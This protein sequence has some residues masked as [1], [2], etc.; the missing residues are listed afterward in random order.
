MIEI[1]LKQI[2]STAANNVI[3]D[4]IEIPDKE[5]FFNAEEAAEYYSQHI[6]QAVDIFDEHFK[7]TLISYVAKAIAES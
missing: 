5:Q 7:T 4:L 2:M 6:N 3:A 1:D